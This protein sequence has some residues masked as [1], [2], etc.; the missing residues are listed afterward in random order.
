[1]GDV[2][3][4]RPPEIEGVEW[5]ATECPGCGRTWWLGRDVDSPVDLGVEAW[6]GLLGECADCREPSDEPR[7]H[8]HV[9]VRPNRAARRAA[10]RRRRPW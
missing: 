2:I 8:A 7:L 5:V 3:Q 10:G 9:A 1:M 6:A 4:E